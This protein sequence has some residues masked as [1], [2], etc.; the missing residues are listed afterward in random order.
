M[1]NIRERYLREADGFRILEAKE[2]KILLVLSVLRLSIFAGGIFLI[3]FG[4]TQSLIAGF[5]L[6][7][8]LAILFLYLLKLYS[9]HS[10]KKIFLG[11][12]V[13]GKSE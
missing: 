1:D 13:T 5:L 9:D 7:P 12:L 6:I 11:K 4:F 8:V 2:E 10:E 3:W